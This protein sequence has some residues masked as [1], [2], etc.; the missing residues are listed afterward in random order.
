M[1]QEGDRHI[2][3]LA[4]EEM[5]E[6]L[7][8]PAFIRWKGRHVSLRQIVFGVGHHVIALSCVPVWSRDTK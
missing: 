7:K 3:I 5:L 8:N 2:D 1:E 6:T 4:T